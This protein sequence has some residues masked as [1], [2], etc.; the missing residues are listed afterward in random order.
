MDVEE[1]KS[2]A[3]TPST[4]PRIFKDA[5]EE[6]RSLDSIKATGSVSAVF[7]FILCF[8]MNRISSRITATDNTLPGE[9]PWMVAI[10]E[11]TSSGNKEFVC[12]GWS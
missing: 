10:L 2:V 3:F 12:G 9:F 11:K 1:T 4:Q 6:I 8:Q 5:A 7:Q